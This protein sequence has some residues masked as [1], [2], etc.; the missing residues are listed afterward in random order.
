MEFPFP[1]PHGIAQGRNQ[2]IPEGHKADKGVP[3]KKDDHKA[4]GERQIFKKPIHRGNPLCL[5]IPACPKSTL[6]LT[7]ALLP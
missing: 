3:K 2:H 6:C 4:V 1:D 7:K 5:T